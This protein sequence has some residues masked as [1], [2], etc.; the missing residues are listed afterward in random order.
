MP[1]RVAGELERR[2]V[3]LVVDEERRHV[4]SADTPVG[5]VL[6]GPEAEGRWRERRNEV[7]RSTV[8][9]HVCSGLIQECSTGHY[10]GKSKREVYQLQ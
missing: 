5:E 8:G 7:R 4:F 3:R 2:G 6:V 1:G 10:A 9:R